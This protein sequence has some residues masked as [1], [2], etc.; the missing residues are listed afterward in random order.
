M[1]E[2]HGAPR[3]LWVT[4][5]LFVAAAAVFGVGAGWNLVGDKP[6]LHGY[7]FLGALLVVPPTALAVLLLLLAVVWRRRPRRRVRAL[8]AAALVLSATQVLLL[9]VGLVGA[10]VMSAAPDEPGEVWTYVVADAGGPAKPRL[11]ALPQ[12]PGVMVPGMT[13]DLRLQVA[14]TA[15]ETSEPLEGTVNHWGPP[16]RTAAITSS[17][18]AG[19]VVHISVVTQPR[20]PRPC[21]PLTREEVEGMRQQLAWTVS[22]TLDEPGVVVQV[23]P[24]H[25]EAWPDL[26]PDPNY[27]PGA[28]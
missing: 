7:L 17:S 15:F 18:V 16:C 13:D 25:G 26:R 8:L 12:A 6:D 22:A 5:A 2:L 24:T 20:L 19:Q 14:L 11:V 9:L 4:T 3:W 21:R 27:A 28:P 1:E 10:A 23:A